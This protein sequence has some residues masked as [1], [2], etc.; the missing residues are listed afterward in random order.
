[1]TSQSNIY[2]LLLVDKSTHRYD[3]SDFFGLFNLISLESKCLL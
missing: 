1:M 2:D 3:I